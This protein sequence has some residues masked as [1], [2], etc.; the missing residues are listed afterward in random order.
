MGLDL[1]Q[2]NLSLIVDKDL[3]IPVMYDLYPG[4]IA[5]VSTLKNTVQKIKA[6]GVRNYTMIMDRGFFSTDR[7]R[8]DGVCGFTHIPSLP[9]LQVL[10]RMSKKRYPPFIAASMIPW[11]T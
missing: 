7:Y 6:Q 8:R 2:I 11:S 9:R 3:G 1:P 5:D 10:S 4:S